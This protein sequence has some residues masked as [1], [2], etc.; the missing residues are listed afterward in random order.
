M[1][2]CEVCKTPIPPDFQN[3]L[4]SNCYQEL[5][6]RQELEKKLKEEEAKKEAE[7][8]PQTL[9]TVEVAPPAQPNAFGITNPNYT[10]NPEM[11]DKEQWA[12][13][14]MQFEST[15][16]LIWHPTRDMYEF[17]KTYCLNKVTQHPQYPKFIWKPKIVDVGCGCGVGSNILSQEA[18][19][20]WGIDKNKRS[21][22]FAKEAFTRVKNGIYYSSQ[23]D[24]AH[25]DIMNET[26]E[27][28]KFDVVVAIEVIEHIYDTNKFIKTLIEH[29][30]KRD[31][32]GSINENDQT[33]FFFSTP[34]R[35][36]KHIAKDKPFNKY[37]VREW[38]S[39]EFYNLLS[40]YFMKVELFNSKGGPI[41]LEE[42]NTTVHTPLL[43]KCKLQ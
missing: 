14:V 38:T 26:R 17:I 34:N 8:K 10:E 33:E 28:M 6:K 3:L 32:H 4:C 20:V 18:E 19:Y 22:D 7:T 25:I 15:G 13:N 11:E 27:L 42:Y 41:P 24:F 21:V 35:N 29:F 5:E 31:K 30:A 37:H 12:T 36:N 43:A 39:Q 16:K 2:Q 23:V 1:K 40:K 9:P